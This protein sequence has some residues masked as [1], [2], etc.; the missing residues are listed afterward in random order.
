MRSDIIWPI[1]DLKLPPRPG[2]KCN[3]CPHC[4]QPHFRRDEAICCQ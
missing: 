4:G 3:V 2:I 1:E